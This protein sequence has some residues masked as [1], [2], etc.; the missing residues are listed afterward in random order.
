MSETVLGVIPARYAST[1][2]PGKPLI[3]IA[4]KPLIQWVWEAAC[5]CKTLNDIVVATDDERIAAACDAFGAKPVMTSPECPSGSDRMAEAIQGR[6]CSI[7]VNIQGDEPLI[8]PATIDECVAALIADPDAGVS[9]AMVE[10]SEDEEYTQPHMVKV[11]T[12]A[13]GHAMYF[14]RAPIPDMRRLDEA[15]RLSAPRAMKHVGLYVYRREALEQ[16]V[17]LPPS[18]YEMTEKLEQLRLMEAGIKIRMVKIATAAVGVDTPED[19]ERV[20]RLL[21][22]K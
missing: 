8:D 18:P 19:L 9:S 4:G 20:E 15:E 21:R 5:R 3:D 11:V 14:S 17:Q 10:F 12:S 1:R 13:A 22:G 7:V 16:F 6:D 2:L